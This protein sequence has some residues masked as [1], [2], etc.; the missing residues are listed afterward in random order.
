MVNNSFIISFDIG[1]YKYSFSS[2]IFFGL[3]IT[4]LFIFYI[5]QYLYFKTRLSFSR[6]NLRSK[7]NKLEKGYTF[8]VDAMIAIANKDNKRAISSHKKMLSYL[9]ND[10]SLSLLLK[11]EVLKIEKKYDQLSDVYEKMI[12]S[13]YTETLGY[14]GLMEQNLNRQDY[15]HAFIYGEKLFFL[16]SKIEKLLARNF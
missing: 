14:R 10:P 4:L 3:V 13:K 16:F 1:D 11:A 8:F 6:Y 15:H 9:K 7:Y 5:L 2:S 12:K